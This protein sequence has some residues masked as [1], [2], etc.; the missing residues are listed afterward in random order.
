MES[1]PPPAPRPVR[2]MPSYRM[3]SKNPFKRELC[4]YE[5]KRIVDREMRNYK[6]D[7][8]TA[9]QVCQTLCDKIKETV[10][11]HN[12]DRYRT[13]VMVSLGEK[14]LQDFDQNL[15]FLVDPENDKYATYVLDR[16]DLFVIV[17]VYAVYKE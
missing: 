6:Y 5:M 4:E 3:C 9:D 2:Y 10:K 1:T 7:S 12:Y 16:P 14:A 8:E 13:I 17:A 11:N 15:G